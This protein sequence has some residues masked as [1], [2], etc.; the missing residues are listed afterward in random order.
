MAGV[1]KLSEISTKAEFAVSMAKTA[2]KDVAHPGPLWYHAIGLLNA[3]YAINEELKNRTKNGGDDILRTTIEA[4]WKENDPEVK[5]FF[6]SARNKAT[7]QGEVTVEP[8][9]EWEDDTINETEHP[10][11]I[12]RITIK[13]T[14]IKL[15]VGRVFGSNGGLN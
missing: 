6:G 1:N 10:V 15:S 7:H 4:W 12:A 3:F 14:E 13:G 2:R 5:S 9:L 11:P 8:E